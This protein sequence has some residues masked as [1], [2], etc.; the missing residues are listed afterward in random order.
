MSAEDDETVETD[1][2]PRPPHFSDDALALRFAAEHADD[3]RYVAALA[4]WFCWEGARWKR[5]NTLSTLDAARLICRQAASS[6]NENNVAHA[7]A[8]AKTV[9]AV[10]RLAKSDRRLAATVEQFDANPF[11]LGTPGMGRDTTGQ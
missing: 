7:I 6:C 10:E 2:G 9:A 5:D 1:A 11:M 3:R 4:R 8:S